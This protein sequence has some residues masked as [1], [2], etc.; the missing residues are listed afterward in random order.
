MLSCRTRSSINLL[1]LRGWISVS[2]LLVESH[3]FVLPL[4]LRGKGGGNSR[5]EGRQFVERVVE[6]A[7]RGEEGLR[8]GRLGVEQLGHGILLAVH[9]KVVY[10]DGL[11]LH[12]PPPAP[13]QALRAPDISP[14][15]STLTNPTRGTSR[16]CL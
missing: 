11:A 9:G 3:R 8:L 12:P 7:A 6:A 4:L 16:C 10:C 14:T 5:I 13:S 2:L 1:R 15:L